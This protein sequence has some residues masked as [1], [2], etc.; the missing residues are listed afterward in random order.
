MHWP[1]TA[2]SIA[3]A[4][5]SRDT[6]EYFMPSVPIPMPSVTVGNPNTCAFASPDAGAAIA[7]STRGRVPALPGTQVSGRAATPP[8]GAGGEGAGPS[9]GLRAT[10]TDPSPRSGLG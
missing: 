3:S 5:T 8:G 9:G 7:Q 2:T 6:S 1:M 4:I 10:G